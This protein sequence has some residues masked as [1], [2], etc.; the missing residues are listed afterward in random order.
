MTTGGNIVNS[1]PIIYHWVTQSPFA[2]ATVFVGCFFGWAILTVTV[3]TYFYDYKCGPIGT[4]LFRLLP[5]QP[6]EGTPT[7]GW[8]T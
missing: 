2:A 3:S 6:A 4:R 7:L 5:W 8:L 1:L